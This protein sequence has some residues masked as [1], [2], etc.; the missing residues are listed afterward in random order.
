NQI[1]YSQFATEPVNEHHAEK[2]GVASADVTTGQ[3]LWNRHYE[4]TTH[5]WSRYYSANY[6]TTNNQ[7]ISILGDGNPSSGGTQYGQFILQLSP[8]GEVI[9]SYGFVSPG[10][11]SLYEF[12]VHEYDSEGNVILAGRHNEVLADGS[13]KRSGF[14]AKYDPDFNLIWAKILA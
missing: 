14:I 9:Q 1:I 12:H 10:P 11:Y 8:D 5:S 6:T 4:T 2:L 13:I 3:V 7:D